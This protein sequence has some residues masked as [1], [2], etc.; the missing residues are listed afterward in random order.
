MLGKTLG[1]HS[2]SACDARHLGN[3]GNIPCLVCGPGNGP[4]HAPNEFINI[5]DYLNYIKFL[6][7]TVY[8]WCK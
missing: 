2:M 5:E 1:V 7:L 3:Q 4:A 8:R 6:A